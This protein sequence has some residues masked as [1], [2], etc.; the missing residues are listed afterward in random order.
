MAC[1]RK[2]VLGLGTHKAKHLKNFHSTFQP[3]LLLKNVDPCKWTLAYEFCLSE[4]TWHVYKIY[5]LFFLF[6]IDFLVWQTY[7]WIF[8][9][10]LIVTK[11]PF[12][13][14]NLLSNIFVF[15]V[16]PCSFSSEF[17]LSRRVANSSSVVSYQE[18]ANSSSL[19]FHSP[20]T[21]RFQ[22]SKIS[23]YSQGSS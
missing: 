23:L 14:Q 7:P 15:F 9:T 6:S 19:A 17:S 21:K 13:W 18:G 1:K 5:V 11:I 3:F 20:S 4:V 16:I 8:L 12:F 2:A 22:L 10:S